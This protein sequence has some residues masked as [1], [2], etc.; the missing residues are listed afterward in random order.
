MKQL[1][2]VLCLLLSSIAIAAPTVFEP[3]RKDLYDLD[4]YRYYKWGIDMTGFQG[5]AIT[6]AELSFDNITNWDN[7]KNRLYIHLLDNDAKVNGLVVRVDS[8][9]NFVD[10]F[11]GKGVLVANPYWEDT[12]GRGTT[13]DLVFT[14]DGGLL[15]TLNQ[16]VANNGYIAFGFDPDCHYWNDGVKFTVNTAITPAPIVPAPGALLLAG[17]GTIVVGLLRVREV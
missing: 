16:Y 12:N 6:S 9:T 4:H 11:A 15:A 10:A 1:L 7:N 5:M 14:F 8:N 2:V 13:E 17:L 3:S